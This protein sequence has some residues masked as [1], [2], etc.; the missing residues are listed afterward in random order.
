[1]RNILSIIAII[2][3]YLFVNFVL[4]GSQELYHWKDLTR[5]N[6]LE[7]I[8]EQKE[9]L[10]TECDVQLII[11]TNKLDQEGSEIETLENM[12]SYY[13]ENEL[14]EF[15]DMNVD[16]YNL[17]ID[18]YDVLYEQYQRE[19]ESCKKHFEAGNSFVEEINILYEKTNK[20]M[21]IPM[22]RGSAKRGMK[23]LK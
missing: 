19:Y 22:P 21:L 14:H 5:I 20:F 23:G 9:A 13:E 10:A 18:E 6:E 11:F 8:I 16:K 7:K 3:F 15:Y 2:V 4:W 12:M 17:I 1:M